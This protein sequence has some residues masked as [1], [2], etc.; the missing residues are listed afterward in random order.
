MR[1]STTRQGARKDVKVVDQLRILGFAGS[2][3]RGS[4][5]QGLIRAATELAPNG[6]TLETFSDA[7]AP[8]LPPRQVSAP[9]RMSDVSNRSFP[10]G[11]NKNPPLIRLSRTRPYGSSAG[12]SRSRGADVGI[13]SA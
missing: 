13:G 3:R 1:A 2:L 11:S 7:V 6:I 12:G 9:R 4:Y 5:N 10:C 8:D